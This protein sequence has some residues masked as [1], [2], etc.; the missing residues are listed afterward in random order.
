MSKQEFIEK[1]RIALSGQIPAGLIEENL[2]YYEEYINS[3]IRLGQEESTVMQSLGDPRLIAKSIITANKDKSNTS[4]NDNRERQ[5][6]VENYNSETDAQDMLKVIR[7]R[8]CLAAGIIL[9]VFIFIIVLI[10]SLISLLFPVIVIGGILYFL[11]KLF[12]DWLN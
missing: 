7:V 5:S 1:M 4:G 10:F 9:C 11:V 6:D 12:R 3:Q 2:Q 8:G